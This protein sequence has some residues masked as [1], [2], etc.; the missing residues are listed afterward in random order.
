MELEPASDAT[1][2][3]NRGLQESTQR[4]RRGYKT[5]ESKARGIKSGNECKKSI[6]IPYG[7]VICRKP[8][9]KTFNEQVSR[10]KAIPSDADGLPRRHRIHES[11]EG[12]PLVDTADQSRMR[13]RSLLGMAFVHTLLA[14][15][16]T[17][18][19]ED[20]QEKIN[21]TEGGE[22]TQKQLKPLH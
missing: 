1:N 2:E 12:T 16:T 6:F 22:S 18:L 21:N 3:T 4:A 8:T 17:S 13:S 11:P 9:P 5:T 15:T 19:R 7:L 14:H 20:E 10:S